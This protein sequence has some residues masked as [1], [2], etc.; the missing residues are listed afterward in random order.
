MKTD[1]HKSHDQPMGKTRDEL[2]KAY[3]AYQTSLR[4]DYRAIKQLGEAKDKSC[5][6]GYHTVF[7]KRRSK[8]S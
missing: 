7:A 5:E 4:L 2:D 1:D 3:K 6:I 8:V